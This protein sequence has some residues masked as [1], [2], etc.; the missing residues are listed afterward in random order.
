MTY[1]TR[2]CWKWRTTRRV[3]KFTNFT[4]SARWNIT[5]T[6]SNAYQT[7]RVCHFL[8]LFF[9]FHGRSPAELIKLEF[10]FNIDK[11]FSGLLLKNIAHDSS[12]FWTYGNSDNVLPSF[13]ETCFSVLCLHGSRLRKMSWLDNKTIA[14]LCFYFV[15]YAIHFLSL[16]YNL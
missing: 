9:N 3:C 13:S 6:N 7:T 8:L 2:Q 11:S 14:S 1:S 15:L 16:F 10:I 12:A 5:G 4:D